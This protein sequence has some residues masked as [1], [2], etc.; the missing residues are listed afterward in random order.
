MINFS[1]EISHMLMTGSIIL[2]LQSEHASIP[3]Q[4]CNSL[5]ALGV[6]QDTSEKV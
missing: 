6:V 3:L 2:A 4:Y 5:S 1:R